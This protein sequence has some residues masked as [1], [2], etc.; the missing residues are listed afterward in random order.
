MSHSKKNRYLTG[1]IL[2]AV[3]ANSSKTYYWK[4]KSHETLS[5]RERKETLSISYSTHNYNT[6]I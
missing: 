3:Y 1:F 5:D 4:L 2:K 6:K